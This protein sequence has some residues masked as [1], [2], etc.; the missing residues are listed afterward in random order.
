MTRQ[1]RRSS[2]EVAKRPL[3]LTRAQVLAFRRR[4]SGLDKRLPS[5]PSS[6]RAAAWAGLT[7][8]ERMVAELV[9]RGLTNREVAQ[10]IFLSPHTVSFHLRKVYRKLGI[11]SRRTLGRAMA[12]G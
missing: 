11:P 2:V 8:S 5:G 12:D 3:R 4:S 9:A 6:L 7:D 10:R 1:P